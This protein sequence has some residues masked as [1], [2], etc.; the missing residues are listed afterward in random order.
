ME[1]NSPEANS[2][3]L[4]LYQM[5]TGDINAQ[6]SMFDVGDTLGLEKTAAGKIAEELIG[7][8]FVEVKTLSGGIGITAQGIEKVKAGGESGTAPSGDLDL[9]K[10]PHL[11]EKGRQAVA[12]IMD[13][14]KSHIA[15]NEIAYDQIEEMV[16]DLKTM[17]VQ[18][19]SP[20][21]KTEV[22]RHVLRSLQ[23]S[24]KTS[25][26]AALA[27]KIRQMTAD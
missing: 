18:M 15:R 13:E 1:S 26:S 16:I 6:V 25:G 8:G 5:T 14:I 2:F 27:D 19:L 4:E 21:P 23:A 11:E 10:G 7:D 24:L 12:E 3:L 17:E 22:M 9:G 20:R